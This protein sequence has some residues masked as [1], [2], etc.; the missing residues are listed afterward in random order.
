CGLQL[1]RQVSNSVLLPAGVNPSTLMNLFTYE[2]GFCFVSYLSELSGDVRRFD[3]FLKD[4][5]SE[6]KFQS[7]VAQDLIAYFLRYF[8][9]LQDAAVPQ[10]EGKSGLTNVDVLPFLLR[11]ITSCPQV[12]SLSV[13]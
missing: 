12:W 4:Y 1:F 5:I 7:V 3:S 9:E 8:P 13:G 11:D 6:F 10:R 2:K